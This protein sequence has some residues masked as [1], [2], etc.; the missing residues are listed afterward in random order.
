MTQ[1]DVRRLALALPEAVEAPHFDRAS[2]RVRGRIF[3]TLP[4]KGDS[5]VLMLPI[6][7]QS[8]VIDAHPS[9]IRPLPAVWQGRG[10]TEL[11][12]EGISEDELAGLLASAWR[13]VAPRS[14]IQT[15]GM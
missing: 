4:P 13:K 15:S 11:L 12:L 6:E 10:S 1:D 8:A 14:L 9:K 5:V 2:F 3:A 7:I